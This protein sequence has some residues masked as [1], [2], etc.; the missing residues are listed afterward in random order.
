MIG[1]EQLW[2]QINKGRNG[3]NIGLSTG[4]PKLDKVIGGIQPSRYYTIAAQSSAGKSSLMQF[5][6]YN[7]LKQTINPHVYFLVFSLEIP[8]SVFL[9]KLLGLYCAEEFGIY[10]TLDD[11]MSFQQP[12]NDY[13]F[14]CLNKAR[15]WLEEVY[16]RI[17][18]IDKLANAKVIYRETLNFAEK[19]G[20]F[21]EINGRKIYKPKFDK[22]LLIGTIDHGLLLQPTEGRTVK[23]EID[24]TSS[25]MVTLKNKINMSWIML[26]QQ[27]R[28]STSMD[29]RKA[30]LD[31]PGLN[32]IKSTGNVGADSD[33]VLQVYY[34]FREKLTTYRGYKLLGDDGIGRYHRSIIVSKQRY[35]IADQVINI[36]FFGSIGWW[37]ELDPPEKI[38]DYNKYKHESGNIPCKIKQQEKED[39]STTKDIVVEKKPLTF[40][41]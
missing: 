14:N 40:S 28:D 10:L 9:A 37:K 15:K 7:L 41:F 4:I 30:G 39:D 21:E 33:C 27:N 8:E 24:L 34:P 26:M 32:D 1:I 12:L 23:E 18:I 5:I 35:G 6:I 17:T 16:P 2:N 19:Y 38:Q 25:Y 11:I 31:E 22:Q 29:R 36:N 13:A 3:E 20:T